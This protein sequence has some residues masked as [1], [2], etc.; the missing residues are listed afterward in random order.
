MVPKMRD[1]DVWISWHVKLYGY[2]NDIALTINHEFST[3]KILHVGIF[4]GPTTEDFAL[5]ELVKL[6]SKS[7]EKMKS[8][9][10]RFNKKQV[11]FV[12]SGNLCPGKSFGI[13][14][15]GAEMVI[16]FLYI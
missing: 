7:S 5:I 12:G 10:W 4:A 9:G 1:I 14:A 13:S 15:V 6:S 3:A 8:K 16:M 11:L 2:L